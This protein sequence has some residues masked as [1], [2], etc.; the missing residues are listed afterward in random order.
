MII[1][2]NS[3]TIEVKEAFDE[4]IIEELVTEI[5]PYIFYPLNWWG[6]SEEERLELLKHF[7]PNDFP[8]A[9]DWYECVGIKDTITGECKLFVYDCIFNDPVKEWQEILEQGAENALGVCGV[10]TLYGD[11]T[12]KFLMKKIS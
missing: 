2:I 5:P 9:D 8:D 11:C 12:R 10:I 6:F 3:E 7:K 1:N 4:L